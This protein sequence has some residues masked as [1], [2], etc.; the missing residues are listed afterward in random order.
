MLTGA[1][2][3]AALLLVKCNDVQIQFR[4]CGQVYDSLMVLMESSM[5]KGAM[6][7]SCVPVSRPRDDASVKH[8]FEVYRRCPTGV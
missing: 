8:R 4:F 3:S 1:K 6:A 7:A 5:S 2:H